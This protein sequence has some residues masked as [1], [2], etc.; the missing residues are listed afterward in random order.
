MVVKLRC[1][2]DVNHTP[3]KLNDV[4]H[5]NNEEHRITSC[6]ILFVTGANMYYE[7]ILTTV[8]DRFDKKEI[9]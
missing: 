5:I 2:Y 8:Q 9:E 7:F 3:F 1:K 4:I 6:N